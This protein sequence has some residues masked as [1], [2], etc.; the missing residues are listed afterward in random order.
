MINKVLLISFLDLN[1]TTNPN[2]AF[3]NK[4]LNNAPKGMLFE[5]NNSLIKTLDAQLGIKPIIAL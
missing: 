1:N 2:P 3:I 5:M 4:P